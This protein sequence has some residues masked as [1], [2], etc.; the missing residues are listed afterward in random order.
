LPRA[1]NDLGIALAPKRSN[2]AGARHF[3]GSHPSETGF[4]RRRTLNLGLV[5]SLRGQTNEAIRQFAGGLEAKPD[6]PE[7]HNYLGSA[8]YRQGR[9][10]E[11][12]REFQ[13]ALKLKPDYAE[14]RKKP[15][16][17]V[18]HQDRRGEVTA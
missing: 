2:G 12:I 17:G 10:G 16:C 9:T 11:A 7:A 15:Q 4:T 13:E 6:Y 5:L 14:A 3:P 18:G 8:W 1:H